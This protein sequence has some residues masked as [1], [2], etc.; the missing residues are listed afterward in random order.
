MDY[1]NTTRTK[2]VSVKEDV[3]KYYN[4]ASEHSDEESVV[5]HIPSRASSRETT[6]L[7]A[8]DALSNLT[9]PV[10][11]QM[12]LE[13]GLKCTGRKDELLERLRNE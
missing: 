1:V 9:L 13:R 3:K 11:K 5:S 8:A 10:L 7:D 2:S 12:C 4:G 6:V